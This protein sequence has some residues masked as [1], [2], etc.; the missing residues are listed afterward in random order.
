MKVYIMLKLYLKYHSNH[1]L[2]RIEK[3][4]IPIIIYKIDPFPK[5]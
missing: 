1:I 2:I 4:K 3:L 5:R